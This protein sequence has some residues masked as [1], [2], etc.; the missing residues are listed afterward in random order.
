MKLP[1]LLENNLKKVNPM[2]NSTQGKSPPKAEFVKSQDKLPSCYIGGGEGEW[3]ER[4]IA[5]KHTKPFHKVLESL[6]YFLFNI[7]CYLTLLFV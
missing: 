5:K 7:I 2:I 3:G 1:L 4:A 6:T